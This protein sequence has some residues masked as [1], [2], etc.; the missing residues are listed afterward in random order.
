MYIGH[1]LRGCRVLV[2][3]RY[4]SRK[5]LLRAFVMTCSIILFWVLIGLFFKEIKLWGFLLIVLGSIC[6]DFLMVRLLR[7]PMVAKYFYDEVKE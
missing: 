1:K 3:K 5:R 2:L 4:F 7:I 6:I